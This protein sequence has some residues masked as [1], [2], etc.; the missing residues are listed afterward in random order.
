MRRITHY[1]PITIPREDKKSVLGSSQTS[2]DAV[3]CIS[4]P[5]LC[6][7]AEGLVVRGGLVLLMK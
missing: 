1:S 2:H 5:K 3:T 7:Y 4:V 6:K